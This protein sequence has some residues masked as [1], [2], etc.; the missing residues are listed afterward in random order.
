MS[1]AKDIATNESFEPIQE[2]IVADKDQLL[3]SFRELQAINVD[4]LIQSNNFEGLNRYLDCINKTTLA[5]SAKIEQLLI[6]GAK[7][8]QQLG[9]FRNEWDARETEESLEMYKKNFNQNFMDLK[10]NVSQA[11]ITSNM[12]IN[13][14][15]NTTVE[16]T[17]KGRYRVKIDFEAEGWEKLTGIKILFPVEAETEKFL[18]CAQD[19]INNDDL[20][21]LWKYMYKCFN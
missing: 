2:Q 5:G 15:S 9:I 14:C 16:V 3:S 4:E 18:E 11:E 12:Q 13:A 7:L 6:E 10:E 19:C 1:I 8:E 17:Y 20:L 21:L